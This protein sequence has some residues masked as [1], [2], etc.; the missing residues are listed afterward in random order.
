MFV[1]LFL[2]FVTEY[3]VAILTCTDRPCVNHVAHEDT[4]ITHLTC[5]GHLQNHLYGRVEENVAAH[6]GDGYTLNHIG[7]IL[8]TTVD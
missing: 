6:D 5:M 4:A 2:L 7:A 3:C 1:L 8:D